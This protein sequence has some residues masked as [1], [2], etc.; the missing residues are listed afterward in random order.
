[1]K[2]T[3]GEA[4]I[5][6]AYAAAEKIIEEHQPHPLPVGAAE[7]MREVVMDFEKEQRV[8]K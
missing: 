1:M 6:R 3:G 4:M 8:E 2:K 5:E 7:T